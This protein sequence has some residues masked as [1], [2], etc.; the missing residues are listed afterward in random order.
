MKTHLFKNPILLAAVFLLLLS[1]G[2]GLEA[3]A[4]KKNKTTTTASTSS[5]LDKATIEAALDGAYNKFKDLQEGKNADYIKELAN[6]DPHIFG[7]ALVTTDGQV[8]TKG[9]ID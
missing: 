4:Q 3:K 1:F 5:G 9:N 2:F 6:V 8:F 7:I